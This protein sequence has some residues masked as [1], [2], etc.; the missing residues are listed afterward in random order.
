MI[1]PNSLNNERLF[2]S[3][4]RERNTRHNS[5]LIP[6]VIANSLNCI[7]NNINRKKHQSNGFILMMNNSCHNFS[8]NSFFITPK[9]RISK[10][11]RLQSPKVCYS[12]ILK[13]K[14]GNKKSVNFT[15]LPKRLIILKEVL[16]SHKA[17]PQKT[18]KKIPSMSYNIKTE[19]KLV[20]LKAYENDKNNFTK[21]LF[22]PRL[23]L[24]KKNEPLQSFLHLY[25]NPHFIDALFHAK[26]AQ[27]IN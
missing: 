7:N 13:S 3:I 10:S 20:S 14:A 18:L 26:N 8:S 23:S 1:K 16:V 24:K 22:D 11:K 5:A 6:Q 15:L 19:R 4:I 25:S 27:S 12:R 17:N 21:T 2:Q 9:K